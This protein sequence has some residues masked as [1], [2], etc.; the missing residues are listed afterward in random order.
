M[1]DETNP[2]HL[3]NLEPNAAVFLDDVVRVLGLKAR[4]L[5]CKYFYDERGSA[6]FEAICELDE[7]YLTRTELAIMDQAVEQMAVQI[8]AGVMLIEFG[9]GSSRKTRMLLDHLQDPVAY[10]SVDISREH[11]AR[12]ARQLTAAYPRI[13]VLPVCADFNEPF[14]L[15][16]AAREPARN[17]VYFPGSTIGN[18]PPDDAIVFLRRIAELCGAGGGLLIGIDLKKDAAVLESAYNDAD[19]VTA[20]FNL[21]LLQRINR[22]LGANFDLAQ[23]QHRAIY[24]EEQG[25]V[26]MYLVSQCQ[27]TVTVGKQRFELA[28]GELIC[29]EYSYKYGIQQF[30]QMAAE[31]RLSQ[32][33]YWTDSQARFAVLYFEVAS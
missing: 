26:E 22:E 12:T 19:G 25:R 30:D 2:I 14:Q 11:L 33:Q 13:E 17:V 28:N 27:Q 4:K 9:S 1:P 23:F 6:L 7:Y 5:P 21:N 32:R 24:N 20:Q 10:V 3:L 8:G 18:F 16:S 15:P 29:T 31:V